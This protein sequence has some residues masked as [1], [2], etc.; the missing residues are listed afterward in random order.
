MKI[1]KYNRLYTAQNLQLNTMIEISDEHA[2]YLTIVLRLRAGDRIRVFNNQQGEYLAKLY[3]YSKK[4]YK[5]ELIEQL[6]EPTATLPLIAAPG[7]IKNDRFT[8]LLEKAV[9]LGATAF[10]PVI[11]NRSQ[12]RTL[13]I[14]RLERCIIEA[15][16]QSERLYIPKITAASLL[17]NFLQNSTAEFIIF[18]DEHASSDLSIKSL[19]PSI[20]NSNI[21]VLT[22]PEGGFDN[23]ELRLLNN[24]TKVKSVSLGSYVLRAETAMLTALAQIQLMRGN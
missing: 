21:A 6:K 2:H 5:L 16:E 20:L 17:A 7:I 15:S 11:C 9:E 12:L 18:C 10:L 23:D 4:D 24:S 3:Q 22:G 1:S 13:N 8:F 19:S 14:S